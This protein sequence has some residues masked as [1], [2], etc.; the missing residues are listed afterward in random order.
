M[1]KVAELA[2]VATA[3]R[4][5]PCPLA[6]Y[7]TQPVAGE[8]NPDARLFFIGEAPGKQ[9]DLT[10]RPFVGAAGKIL[11]TLLASIGLRREDVFITSIEKF[12]P[13][14][15]RDP[16]PKEILACFP[17][18][19]QQID[20]V[21]PEFLIPLGRHALRRILEWEQGTPLAEDVLLD[22][23]H[24]KKIRSVRT[25]RIYFPLY[26]PA[27]ALYNR[28]LLTVLQHDFRTLQSILAHASLRK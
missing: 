4:A 5:A 15:N 13:P 27:A 26:H 28:K 8:G 16:K 10:G 11:N 6:R 23:Y 24:G 19:E 25:Q 17:Y 12:R 20:I 2:K 9:E 21:D 18:L 3:L 1:D 7:A 14:D 22:A